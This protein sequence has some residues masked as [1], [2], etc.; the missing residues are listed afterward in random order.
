MGTARSACV[1][2]ETISMAWG[3]TGEGDSDGGP[4]LSPSA[5]LHPLPYLVGAE[6]S[7]PAP[8]I[9]GG[10]SDAELQNGEDEQHNGNPV[11]CELHG[12][13]NPVSNTQE[14]ET[15]QG[16]AHPTLRGGDLG[17]FPS[18]ISHWL[19]RGVT[20]SHF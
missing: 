9:S 20:R 19:R 16:G 4:G 2:L 12:G 8:E 10:H 14:E 1:A 7:G 13:E 5:A 6:A 3:D 18:S 11:P 15:P 17:G